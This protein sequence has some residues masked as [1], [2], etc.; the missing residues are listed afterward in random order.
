MAP[1]LEERPTSSLGEVLRLSIPASLTML[2][3]T[4]IRFVDGLMVARLGGTLGA[5]S[6]SAQSAAGITA[7]AFEAL[8]MGTLTVVNTYVGQNL[9]AR[10][11]GQCGVYAWAGVRIAL[12]TAI[13]LA[14]LAL[15]AGPI[16]RVYGHPAQVQPLEAMYFRYMMLACFLTLPAAVLESF[17][18]GLHRSGTVFAVSVISNS[19][20]VLLN[21]ALIYGEFGLPRLEL[22]GAAIGSLL[23]WGVRLLILLGLFLRPAISRQYHTRK[24]RQ[25]RWSHCRDIVRVGWPAGVTF[26]ND[27][28]TW[29]VFLN[30]LVA[31]FGMEHFTA[32]SIVFRYIPLSFMPA[33]GIGIAATAITGRYIGAGRP[34]LAR[35]RTHTA[36]KVAMVYM[37]ACGLAFLLFGGQMVQFFVRLTPGQGAEQISQEVLARLVGVG[38]DVMICAAV[39][40]LFDAVGI[41]YI[42]AL[43]GAGDTRWPML[44]VLLL[45]WSVIVGGG[46]AMVRGL[47]QLGSIGPW[48]TA[49]LY[50]V[51]LGVLMAWR[52]ETG[53]WQRIDLL[54]RPPD[55]RAA[56]PDGTAAG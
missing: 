22:Q 56:A 48:L 25:V 17:F 20:N 43:R 50:V 37:G 4:V 31:P 33:V 44:A 49:S 14:P 9:G 38:R 8:A 42:G 12:L 16:F 55:K 54:H 2:G 7:F 35:R 21:Y 13:M 45:S 26:W 6:I 15:L 28:F 18:F 46:Y 41:V 27:V 23:A 1:P 19:L 52:F 36:L 51:I 32:T 29:S 10:R 30:L 5:V 11:Y 24:L 53:R 40:Q 47:P 3:T 39:F 34:D